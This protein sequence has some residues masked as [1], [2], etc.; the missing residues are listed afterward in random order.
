MISKILRWLTGYVEFSFSGGFSNDFLDDCFRSRLN[1]FG[2]KFDKNLTAQCSV[3]AYKYLHKIAFRHGGKVKIIKKVG[4]PFYV[5]KLMLRPGLA[6]GLAL[7]VALFCFLSGFI[8]NIEYVGNKTIESS[9]IEAFLDKN[10]FRPG[11]WWKIDDKQRLEDLMLASFDEIA[12]VHINRVGMTAKVEIQEAT[13]K[14]PIESKA[15]TNLVATKDGVIVSATVK[16]GW[17]QAFVG[18][19]VTKGTILV[20]GVYAPEKKKENFF[21]HAS[22]EFI[23]TVEENFSLTVNREQCRKEYIDEREY[24]A[25]SFFGLYLPLYF[26]KIPTENTELVRHRIYLTVNKNPVPVGIVKT[27][28]KT[29]NIYTVTL[30]DKELLDLTDNLVNQKLST[31][32]GKK[33]IVSKDI[34][35]SLSSNSATAKG[36]VTALENIAQEVRLVAKK[37][38]TAKNN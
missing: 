22:G 6:L 19:S 32:Y 29:Y 12:W 13:P 15:Y 1:V 33:N 20:S 11:T 2:V 8:W 16:D 28:A 31:N 7:S 38:K 35:V 26:G 3:Q 14:P 21:A 24:K 36:K 4:L 27:Y 18:D 10:D 34:T 9:R 25:I 17:Q 23:A 37:N 30:S 5:A